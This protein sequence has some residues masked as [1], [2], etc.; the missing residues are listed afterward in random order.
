MKHVGFLHL[1]KKKDLKTGYRMQEIGVFQEHVFGE[2]LSQ[3]GFLMME[4][5]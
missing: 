1:F 2:T 3:F 4:R 5:K